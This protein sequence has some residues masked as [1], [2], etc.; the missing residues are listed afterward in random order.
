MFTGVQGESGRRYL[1]FCEEDKRHGRSITWLA[2]GA[3]TTTVF[4]EGGRTGIF[5]D[6]VVEGSP[7]SIVWIRES[8]G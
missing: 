5:G 6:F 4:L 1:G 2:I 7:L 8:R 3:H